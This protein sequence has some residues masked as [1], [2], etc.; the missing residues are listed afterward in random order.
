VAAA[1]A[2]SPS[3]S[4]KSKAAAGAIELYVAR[5]DG[6]DA[7]AAGLSGLVLVVL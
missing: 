7:G 3:P 2:A 4:K 6:R 5:T 1:P